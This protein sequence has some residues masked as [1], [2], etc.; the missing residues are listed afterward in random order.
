MGGEVKRLR[1]T[2]QNKSDGEKRPTA[3]DR[4]GDCAFSLSG[5]DGDGDSNTETAAMRRRPQHRDDD[6]AETVAMTTR[7]H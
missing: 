1:Q 7:R 5:G 4:N 6:A 3:A 2:Q